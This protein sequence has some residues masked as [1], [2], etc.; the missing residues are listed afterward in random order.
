MRI[1]GC[2][3]PVSSGL[4]SVA[5]PLDV[6]DLISEMVHARQ[7]LIRRPVLRGL[8][9]RLTQGNIGLVGAYVH[10]PRAV[11]TCAFAAHSKFRKR[12]LQETDHAR[13]VA[14]AE[15]RMFQPDSHCT[16]PMR[17]GNLSPCCLWRLNPS[18]LLL[19]P[20]PPPGDEY[21]SAPATAVRCPLTEW[22]TR[23]SPRQWFQSRRCRGCPNR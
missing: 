23:D 10:P 12:R 8:Q 6:I 7:P 13:D 18:A 17:P 14:H 16:P 19:S 22:R 21:A 11:V 2:G 4:H 15:V 20:W 1:R 9:P 3:I 5:Q